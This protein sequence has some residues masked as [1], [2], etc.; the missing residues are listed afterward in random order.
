MADD[1]R[2]SA[3]AQLPASATN[4]QNAPPYQGKIYEGFSSAGI[5]SKTAEN[6]N[7]MPGG[8]QHTAGGDKMKPVAIGDGIATIQP[9][10]FMEIHKYPCVREALMTGIG[11][12]A[13]TGGLLYVLGKP[14]PKAC[15]WGVTMFCFSAAGT[16]EFLKRKL[17]LEK[18]GMG[19][20]VEIMDRKR[21]E[22]RKQK[23]A[24]IAARRKAKEEADRLEEQRMKEEEARKR[25]WWKI[26]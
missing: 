15:N 7:V 17:A 20:A 24:M 19:R 4:S 10:D 12:G 18:E 1:T 23:E 3:P 9:K 13:G 22:K 26:W 14:I 16:Y 5:Q 25:S 11:T 21:E 6:P 2:E 8:T